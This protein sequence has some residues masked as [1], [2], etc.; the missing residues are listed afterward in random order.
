MTPEPQNRPPCLSVV[1][2][3]YN[4]GATL[5]AVVEKLLQLPRL[6]EVVVVDDCSTD[7]TPEVARRLAG[8]DARVRVARHERNQGKTAALR[9]GFALTRGEVVIVQDADLEYDPAEI[10]LVILPILN[11]RADV[12]YGSRFLV[13][14]ATRVLYFYH[15]LGNKFL[16][17]LSN[18]LT[19]LNMTDIETGY[20]AF[21]GEIIRNM[22][23]TS[24]GF[25][26]EVEVTAKVAKLGCAVYEVPI[27]YYGRTYDEGKKIG[28][29]DGFQALWL[30]LRFNLF[31]SLGASF[32]RL[33]ELSQVERHR[34]PGALD[35]QTYG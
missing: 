4:E 21:R 1:V 3:A 10:P 2:P 23:I 26:F 25:G 33:P 17:F 32:T 35:E 27:S 5:E 28:L 7:S 20:K 15:Y 8:G 31:C 9:T 30:I 22:R 34:F 18:V 29:R 6:L 24:R 14:R 13:R 19:N 16:T 11:D 12:V